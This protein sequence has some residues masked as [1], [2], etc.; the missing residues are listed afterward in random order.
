MLR[1]GLI[2]GMSGPAAILTILVQP[3]VRQTADVWTAPLAI[4]VP[5]AT[6]IAPAPLP[7]MRPVSLALSPTRVAAVSRPSD[8]PATVA[9]QPTSDMNEM[10][11]LKPRR[12]REGC[13]GALSSLV[14]PEARR[15]VPGRCIS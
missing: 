3:V 4:S 9:N 2:L 8:R 10:S 6:S 12:M 15:M 5:A 14:G 11:P 13:E 7:G 1:S